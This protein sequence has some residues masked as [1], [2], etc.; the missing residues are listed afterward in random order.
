[1][2]LLLHGDGGVETSATRRHRLGVAM[3]L[4]EAQ[5][6][7]LAMA[8]RQLRPE[9][10]TQGGRGQAGESG[11]GRQQQ[12]TIS[13]SSSSSRAAALEV[14]LLPASRALA[15]NT[16]LLALEQGNQPVKGIN[17]GGDVVALFMLIVERGAWFVASALESCGT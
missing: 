6:L 10:G 9:A 3:M 8:M 12:G 1:M 5:I 16:Q 2:R 13:G 7:D 14:A 15:L 11:Q 4:A 17:G